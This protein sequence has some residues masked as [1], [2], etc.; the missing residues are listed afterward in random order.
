MSEHDLDIIRPPGGGG[1]GGSQGTSG[2][3]FNVTV[4]N[5]DT[6]GG[7]V[8]MQWNGGSDSTNVLTNT[9]TTEQVRYDDD[10]TVTA[11]AL[12]GKWFYGWDINAGPVPTVLD[13]WGIIKTSTSLNELA[14]A[15]TWAKE[16]EILFNANY[17]YTNGSELFRDNLG[18][19]ELQTGY[20]IDENNK[21]FF[22]NGNALPT[23]F[24]DPND[25]AIC[26]TT[27]TQFI[28]DE[29]SYSIVNATSSPTDNLQTAADACVYAESVALDAIEQNNTVQLYTNDNKLYTTATGFKSVGGASSELVVGRYYV[30]NVYPRYFQYNGVIPTL[31]PQCSFP[32][33]TP[34][35]TS[36]GGGGGG[37]NGGGGD[38]EIEI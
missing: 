34:T 7:S 20:H 36:T 18:N 25:N 17:L 6:E 21:I 3:T 15:C 8:R 16:N 10:V 2:L 38:D 37:G 28:Y 11:T 5:T 30:T 1:G 29:W 9:S 32:T 19:E 27:P 31:I 23:Q 26:P 33:P 14:D 35:P 4:D 24:L 13:L 22:Y 12:P